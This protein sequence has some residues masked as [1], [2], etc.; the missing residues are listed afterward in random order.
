MQKQRDDHLR[1]I[2]T[3]DFAVR[4]VA[5]AIWK[6]VEIPVVLVRKP[7]CIFL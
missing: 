7:I 4:L 6:D 5:S 1:G 3:R 2:Y